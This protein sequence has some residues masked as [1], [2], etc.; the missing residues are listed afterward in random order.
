MT[1][2]VLR[3]RDPYM[4]GYETTD[5]YLER[6]QSKLEEAFQTIIY[7]MPDKF[8]EVLE[9][10]YRCESP[11]DAEYWEAIARSKVIDL[12]TPTP[13]EEQPFGFYLTERAPCPLCGAEASSPFYRGFSLPEGL[14]RHLEGYG[15][16]SKCRVMI[17]ARHLSEAYFYKKFAETEKRELQEKLLAIQQRKKNEVLYLIEPNTEPR[18]IDELSYGDVAREPAYL[19]WAE[20]RLT[21][22]GFL[23]STEN[24]VRQY[25]LDLSDFIVFADPRAKSKIEFRVYKTPISS[26]RGSRKRPTS[27]SFC[28]R[29]N[30]TKNIQ[31]QFQGMLSVAVETLLKGAGATVTERYRAKIGAPTIWKTTIVS[32]SFDARSDVRKEEDERQKE[33]ANRLA[34]GE[35]MSRY[36]REKLYRE[37]WAEAIQHVSKRYGLSDTGLAKICERLLIPRPPRGYWAK[38]AAG[39]A[40][41]P[42]P[43][44][45]SIEF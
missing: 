5:E 13:E 18:L 12:A 43:E 41:P 24:N 10:Y 9:S 28:L 34:I 36:D 44:L 23:P 3:F 19:A 29:D 39:K 2:H 31:R 32:P 6:L 1:F 11:A 20:Q 14:N 26:R 16:M 25:V 15:R 40:V 8:R 7:L 17:A 37:V 21:E 30:W 27:Q 35:L 45:P 22:L 33:N 4:R 38:K 42:L